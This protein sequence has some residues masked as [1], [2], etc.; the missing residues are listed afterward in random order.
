VSALSWGVEGRVTTEERSGRWGQRLGPLLAVPAVLVL[1]AAAIYAIGDA[2]LAPAPTPDDPGFVDTI[3]GSRAVVAAVR[4]AVIS[5]GAFIVS[6]VIAL[7]A[8]GQWLTRVGPVQVSD[9]NAE[10]QRIEKS[11]GKYDETVDS[12]GQAMRAANDL[13]KRIDQDKEG[14]E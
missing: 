8:R 3:L 10:R 9:I 5:A 1:V 13:L 4:L 14:V 6:S 7:I 2:V 12:M 11:L